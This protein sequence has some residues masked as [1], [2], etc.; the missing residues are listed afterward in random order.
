MKKFL[1]A[2]AILLGI[3]VSPVAHA[4]AGD[5]NCITVH[6][7]LFGP[8][9]GQDHGFVFTPTT[10]FRALSAFSA[11]AKDYWWQYP[12]PPIREVRFYVI[13]LPHPG[14]EVQLRR[15]T[16]GAQT[17]TPICTVT[18]P[19]VVRGPIQT[20]CDATAAMQALATQGEPFHL[21]AFY[22][23]DGTG[24]VRL[25]ETRLTF[26]YCLGG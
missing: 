7:E 25:Y 2:V 1:A 8:I 11:N 3:V 9:P 17:Q 12:P 20:Q 5:S 24:E 10:E 4:Q 21:G 19:P 15:V 22:R 14:A 18:A 6:D 26:V 13:W 16:D 23:G